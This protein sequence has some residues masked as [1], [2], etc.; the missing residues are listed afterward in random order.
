MGGRWKNRIQL[1]KRH[2]EELRFHRDRTCVGANRIAKIVSEK[3]KYVSV[4]NTISKWLRGATVSADSNLYKIALAAWKALPDAPIGVRESRRLYYHTPRKFFSESD[5]SIL[6]EEISRIGHPL[7]AIW[8][9]LEN[10]PNGLQ[11]LT[12]HSWLRGETK[13]T[14]SSHYEYVLNSLRKFDGECIPSRIALTDAMRNELIHHRKRTGLSPYKVI[15]L[16]CGE[17]MANRLQAIVVNWLEGAVLTV[18]EKLY[19]QVLNAWKN[20]PDKRSA[21]H[22]NLSKGRFAQREIKIPESGNMCITRSIRNYLYRSQERSGLS[23]RV[24]LKKRDDVPDGLTSLVIHSWMSRKAE[25]A[26]AAH[27]RYVL[28]HWPTAS[29]GA[30]E[31][32]F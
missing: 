20:S 26:D 23:P 16:S 13:S 27:L 21:P 1:T 3:T 31:G 6:K 15:D 18:D 19:R 9:C 28:K 22:K 5:I 29:D 25:T 24:F 8:K 10:K 32:E 12:V 7:H 30:G 2:L 14:I 11:L 17:D 4:G